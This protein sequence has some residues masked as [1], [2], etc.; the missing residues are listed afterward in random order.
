MDALIERAGASS[1]TL[2]GK[3]DA[4]VLGARPVPS[5]R[6]WV[7]ASTK[8]NDSSMRAKLA[9]ARRAALGW[10]A[11]G[12]RHGHDTTAFPRT[13]A[14]Q[15]GTSGSSVLDGAGR[16]LGVT[17]ARVNEVA[18]LAAT[19]SAP[20]SVGFGMRGDVAADPGQAREMS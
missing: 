16:L 8:H 5:G 13:A 14:V 6:A 1:R 7:R 18:A 19:A 4:C 15:P 20:Q 3:G 10:V 17:V 11:S 12:G 9:R 2:A